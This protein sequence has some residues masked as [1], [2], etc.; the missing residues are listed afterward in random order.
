V[1]FGELPGLTGTTSAWVRFRE[2]PG[3]VGVNTTEGVLVTLLDVMP[4]GLFAAEPKPWFVPTL[5]FSAHFGQIDD[6]DVGD[7]MFVTHSTAWATSSLCV[8]ESSV[9]DQAGQLRAQSRQV[10]SVRW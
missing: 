6:L 8:D 3:S 4:P 5:S 10:R 2:P 7:W 1:V 9:W